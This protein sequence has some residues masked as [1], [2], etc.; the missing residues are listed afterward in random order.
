MDGSH[1]AHARKHIECSQM[2]GNIFY[3]HL[4]TEEREDPY[5][6]Y[7]KRIAH[8]LAIVD[9]PY[10]V[11]C[12]DDDLLVIEN[13]LRAVEFLECNP[14]YIACHGKYLLYRELAST[15]C[16]ENIAYAG[17]SIDGDEIGVRL[18]QLFSRYEA[19]FY[20]VFRT[21]VQRTL[22]DRHKSVE[23]PLWPEIHH[24]VGA[25]IEGKLKR[26]DNIYSLRNTGIP[27]LS[28][29]QPW[30]QSF[31]EMAANDFDEFFRC[32]RQFTARVL[33]WAV[34]RPDCTIDRRRLGRALDMAFGLYVGREVHLPFWIDKYVATAVQDESARIA[35]RFR[36]LRDLLLA[37]EAPLPL[38]G[39]KSAEI[40]SLVRRR[41][42]GAVVKCGKSILGPK[43]VTLVQ[44]L[45]WA[46]AAQSGVGKE[47]DKRLQVPAWLKEKFHDDEWN[48]VRKIIIELT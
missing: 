25:I 22:F 32:Y 47:L 4:P 10:V 46:R 7:N 3:Y 37:P 8:A 13:A 14:G 44:R 1:D 43:G 27:P 45:H 12:A 33:E 48:L 40:M 23:Q 2:A 34:H 42:Y 35:L 11:F 31:G 26:L 19:P 38:S 5:E 15:I 17:D 28:T 16:V 18:M 20:A 9:T 21:S 41:T 24:S 29:L 6:N 39:G 30:P 36:T